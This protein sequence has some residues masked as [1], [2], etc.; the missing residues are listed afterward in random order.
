MMRRKRLAGTVL[1]LLSTLLVLAGCGGKTAIGKFGKVTNGL[2]LYKDLAIQDS[3][4]EEFDTSRYDFEEYR[5]LLDEEL[6][7][8]NKSHEFKPGDRSKRGDHEP[9]YQTPISVV[10]AEISGQN[11]SQQLIYA[12]AE[13]YLN[14]HEG[15]LKEKKGSVLSTG[16]LSKVDT[17]ILTAS[18]TS[19]SG[20]D[21]NVQELC[22][23]TDAG[24]YRYIVCDFEA[25]IYGDGELICYTK[26]A[27]Y[28][29][30]NQCVTVP[31]GEKVIVIYK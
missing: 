2:Y 15:E 16:T 7:A 30:D 19:P 18:Y 23:D 25:L 29:K 6:A 5:T 27:S 8:Y 1:G 28:N 14:Y 17:S 24:N 22:V 9:N 11:L 20:Q 4:I 26:N 31:G 12:N 13:D 10:K 3:Y 21:V